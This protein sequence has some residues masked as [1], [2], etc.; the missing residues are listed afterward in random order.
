MKIAIIGGGPAGLTAAIYALRNNFE[1][2]LFEMA[3]IGGQAALAGEVENYPAFVK[4]SG[5]DLTEKMYEQAE[6]LGLATEYEEIVKI[7]KQ[8]ET[9]ALKTQSETFIF[10]GVI[11]AMGA[12]ARQL[13]IEED[14]LGRGVSFCATCDGNFFK[15][16]TVVVVGGGD[17]A[18][19]DALY[20]SNIAKKVYLV[21]RR[22][23]FRATPV[24]VES[25]K[26]QNNIE[27]VLNAVPVKICGTDVVEKLEVE[28]NDGKRVINTDAVFIAIGQTPNSRCVSGF[29]NVDGNGYVIADENLQ[30]SVKG[31]YVAGD[32]RQKTLRQIVTATSDG[33]IAAT[34]LV[35]S[36]LNK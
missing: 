8:G 26:K 3:G 34:N 16:K 30:T 31:V 11:L 23:S 14:Y 10:D 2:T 18:V 1:V 12:S 32:V 17:T 36:L 5:Y 13:G 21:H 28:T 29:V 7:E 33:A 35:M 22:D 24:L 4:I 20:L 9:F 6:S 15:D 25:V 19:E 27:F